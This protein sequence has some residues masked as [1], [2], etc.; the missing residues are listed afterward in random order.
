[1]PW[2]TTKWLPSSGKNVST[3]VFQVWKIHAL[4][5]DLSESFS[6]TWLLKSLK[7]KKKMFKESRLEKEDLSCQPCWPFHVSETRWTADLISKRGMSITSQDP[8]VIQTFWSLKEERTV[9]SLL[10]QAHWNIEQCQGHEILAVVE[11]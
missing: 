2:S 7:E 9:C 5:R 6:L 1:M 11:L 3:E 8:S 4:Q 10:S